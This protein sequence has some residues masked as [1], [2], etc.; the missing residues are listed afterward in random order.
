MKKKTSK[1]WLLTL[2]FI[3]G[4]SSMSVAQQT[5]QLSGRSQGKR[6]DG[7]GV[8]NGGGATSVLL[9]DYPEQQRKEI[10]DLVYN[11]CSEVP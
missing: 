8:V 11:Q 3:I 9:K 5:I 4:C 10:M 2:S 1:K 7:I 6:F